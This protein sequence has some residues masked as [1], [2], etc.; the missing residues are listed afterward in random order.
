MSSKGAT[1][2][3]LRAILLVAAL[4]GGDSLHARVL[5]ETPES[6]TLCRSPDDFAS[7]TRYW[8]IEVATDTDSVMVATRAQ[9][10][11]GTLDSSAIAFVHDS[12]TCYRGARAHAVAAG[13]DTI[14]PPAVYLLRIGPTRY[15]AWNGVVEHGWLMQFLFDS[16]FVLLERIGS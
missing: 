15:L 4:V 1:G 9:W 6:R 10:N 13:Q 12:V 7:G 11:I 5:R 3:L 2:V 8:V 16:S 14:S